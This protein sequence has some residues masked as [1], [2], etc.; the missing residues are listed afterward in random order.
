KAFWEPLTAASRA[1]F[2]NT[3]THFKPFGADISDGGESG[4][5]FLI[6]GENPRLF[7]AKAPRINARF[8]QLGKSILGTV[9]SGIARRFPK[10]ISAVQATFFGSFDRDRIN[11]NC[12]TN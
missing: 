4:E 11:K 5:K 8:K 6:I 3:S 1:D 9:N 2:Q 7:Q 10:H 12:T